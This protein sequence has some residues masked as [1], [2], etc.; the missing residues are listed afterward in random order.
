MPLTNVYPVLEDYQ[1][2]Y[3]GLIFGVD[4]SF[5]VL[6]VDGIG[7]FNIRDTGKAFPRHH[8]AIPGHNYAT[9]KQISFTLGLDANS[10]DQ[11][12]TLLEQI[13]D[14]IYIRTDWNTDRPL[15]YKLPNWPQMR[16]NARPSEMPLVRTAGTFHT[17]EIE[18]LLNCSDPHEYS[19]AI[20]EEYLPS[21]FKFENLG[22]TDVYPTYYVQG[23]SS[24]SLTSVTITNNTTGISA[25]FNLTLTAGQEAVLDMHAYRFANGIEPVVVNGVSNFNAWQ[26]PWNVVYL[27]PGNNHL[28]VAYSGTAGTTMCAWRDAWL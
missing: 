11:A 7:S 15:Q 17:A 14:S 2:H 12:E 23:P 18:I 1:F 5:H 10:L 26:A 27:S 21:T 19:D 13:K 4:T 3:D 24:G 22:N 16:A 28:T 20:H 9:S 6:N 25:V 8:G